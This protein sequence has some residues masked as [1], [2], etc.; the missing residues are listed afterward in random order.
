MRASRP[1]TLLR[2]FG[3]M[4]VLILASQPAL[5]KAQ[6]I[7]LPFKFNEVTQPDARALIAG[8][9]VFL[10]VPDLQ[11]AGVTGQ[12][13]ERLI[14]FARLMSAGTLEVNGVEYVSLKSLQPYV[15]F[16][17]DQSTLS[18]SVTSNPALLAETSYNTRLTAPPG[19]VYTKNL[20]TF[21]NYSLTSQFG[22]HPSFFAETGTS[23]DGNL[24]LNSFA[25]T[26]G[27]FERLL[28]SYTIDQRTQLRRWTL[29]DATATTDL[30]GGSGL[31][32]GVTVSSNF[33]LD[34]Y[35]VRYPPLNLSGTALT[36]SR[37]DVYV[38]GMLVSEQE[39]PPGPFQLN[40]IPVQSGAG[41]AQIVVRDV[42]GRTQTI[43]QPY[44]FST[45]VLERGLSEYNY[46]LGAVRRNY[47][48]SSFDYGPPALLAFHR[49][50]FTDNLTAGGRFEASR[51]LV[52][53]GPEGSWRTRFGQFD[54]TLALSDD[55]GKVGNAESFGY[56]Y[57]AHTFSF[58]GV[59]R[60]FSREYG[61]LSMRKEADRPLFDGNVFVTLFASRASFTLLWTDSHMR[62]S[63]T[64]NSVTLLSNVP[65]GRRA[66]LFVSAGRVDQG[67]HPQ[68]QVFTGFSYFFGGSTAASV[69][70]NHSNGQTQTVAEI[71]KT[72]PVGTGLGYRLQ[73]AMDGGTH[74][75]SGVVQYQTDFGRYEVDFDPY[76]ASV[77]PT[78]IAS[79]GI[80][81]EG[82]AFMFARP[83]DDAF[84]LVRIP[85]VEDVRVYSSNNLVGR[86][87]SNGDLLVPNLLSYYGNRLSIDDR[88]IPLSY[89][90][91]DTEKT[92]AP[93]Y[94]GGAFV[95]FPVQRIRAV[96][97]AVSIRGAKGEFFP[98]FGELTLTANGK[99]VQS[100]IGH[101]GQFYFENLSPGTYEAKI[102]ANQGTCQFRVDVPAG[103]EPML[104]LGRQI[105]TNEAI[106]P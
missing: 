11:K 88:D 48:F 64:T 39:V 94:R 44:Y 81:Y 82:G 58:G 77:R 101:G 17:F 79:G 98:V 85:G 14:R 8:D 47:G 36:P 18:L 74:T 65:I 72:L 24:L 52:S 91:Q 69:T 95:V 75:G 71:D 56:S 41:N 45:G 49:Y 40:N 10:A 27:K 57:L 42:Y 73:S 54:L 16:T 3:M 37:V 105:C 50:G 84:A 35:F 32:G 38:N 87:D 63:G 43:S 89:D 19:T 9:D 21:L 31:I 26:Q 92:I 100:P 15:S 33:S 76:H 55:S 53:G 46:S 25:R 59:A 7:I 66:S 4:A 99:S 34:P 28:S 103:S 2:A 12:M 29:G 106:N 60:T 51:D 96:T 68:A 30:L 70:V 83:I 104:K 13:W 22:H 80:V 67:N 20:S 102:E 90:L 61:N 5:A 97:G 6:E 86:T 23:Y 1:V 62:D 78:A 93:P